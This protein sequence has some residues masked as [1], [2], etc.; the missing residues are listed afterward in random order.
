MAAEDFDVLVVG[1][2]SAGAVLASRLSED[3]ALRV[4]LLEAGESSHPLTPMPIS[5]GLLHDDPEVN[6]LYA[7]ELE[8]GL[9][10]RSMR[11]TCGRI[12]GGSSAI[13]GMV[14]T[15]GQRQDYDDWEAL[16]AR[17]WGWREVAPFFERC[18]HFV[19]GEALPA[20]GRSGPIRLSEVSDPNP[21]YDAIFAAGA[22]LGYRRNPD[23]NGASQDGLALAQASIHLGRRV[24]VAEG[25]LEE[26][27]QRP[28]LRVMTGVQVQNLLLDGR[29]CTGAA[30][31]RA[32]KFWHVGAQETVLCAGALGSP[33]L[34][35]RSGIGNPEV[36]GSLG[37]AV[38]HALPAVGENLRDHLNTPVVW[39][40]K[41]PAHSA[42]HLAQ[43]L[44]AFRQ[45][46]RYM[47]QGTGLMSLPFAPLL[48]FLK[49]DPLLAR[50]DVQMHL[51]PYAIRDTLPRRSEEFP[52]MT[53]TSCVLRP[54]SVGAVHL[55]SADPREPPGI[56]FNY[57]D[58]PQDQQVAL[59]GFRLL[60]RL[61]ATAPMPALILDE[62]A[63]G[64]GVRTDDEV[65]AWIAS[66]AQSA[67]HPVGTCRMGSSGQTS[68]VDNKLRV[69]GIGGLRIADASVFPSMPSGNTNAPAIMLGERA[70]DILRSTLALRRR[71]ESSL[72]VGSPRA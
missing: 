42:N 27:R 57:L 24:S 48:G 12:L 2:G 56:R 7:S 31:R 37:I 61:M 6:W 4:L 36:L 44:P 19:G 25:Y 47:S 60:R 28:N 66:R 62:F 51:M 72:D 58:S 64:Q 8:P 26:A 13:N 43:G 20:R 65:L 23:Y 46:L 41:D 32:D 55:R 68:V 54:E 30:Y 14:W 35:E 29:R 49:T 3:P 33:Q 59:R 70:A 15:R 21:L 11:V 38:V 63:P 1:A 40:L 10:R 16:G 18:E 39:R 53:S 45:L 34:L 71:V 69:H 5:F 9:A 17:G 52:A 22:A 67:C 50:P